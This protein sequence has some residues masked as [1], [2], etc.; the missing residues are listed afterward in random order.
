M[1]GVHTVK[2]YFYVY[3]VLLIRLINCLPLRFCIGPNNICN[4]ISIGFRR[5]T[6]FV[7]IPLKISY[8]EKSLRQKPVI[9]TEGNDWLEIPS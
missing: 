6:G 3:S 1:H 4:Y 8:P 9:L 2:A 7:P 5:K